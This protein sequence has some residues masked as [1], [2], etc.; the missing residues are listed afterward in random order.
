MVFFSISL[1][2][3]S[4]S[5]WLCANLYWIFIK[6]Q[7]GGDRCASGGGFKNQFAKQ[8]K[9]TP[10]LS[11]WTT[12]PMEGDSHWNVLKLCRSDW[13][14]SLLTPEPCVRS[15]WQRPKQADFCALCWQETQDSDP[16]CQMAPRRFLLLMKWNILASE[17]EIEL[18]IWTHEYEYNQLDLSR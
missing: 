1:M 14:D 15:L 3:Q 7:T 6:T 12:L 4:C 17:S 9:I 10:W 18:Y 13:G 8:H 11:P 5:S 16:A 2:R